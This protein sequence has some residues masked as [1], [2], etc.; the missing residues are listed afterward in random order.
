MVNILTLIWNSLL[1]SKW[2]YGIVQLLTKGKLISFSYSFEA[3]CYNQLVITLAFHFMFCMKK[4]KYVYF[5]Y[6]LFLVNCAVY[7]SYHFQYTSNHSYFRYHFHLQNLWFWVDSIR[8]LHALL[9]DFTL[10]LRI[11]LGLNGETFFV[12]V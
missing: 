7:L 9:A 8:Y 12:K 1:L 10:V 3:I 5:I 4:G 11:F 6:M 2:M